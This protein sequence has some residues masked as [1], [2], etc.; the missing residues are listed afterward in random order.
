MVTRV[1]KQSHSINCYNVW[2]EEQFK[3][4]RENFDWIKV[5]ELT[6]GECHLLRYHHVSTEPSIKHNYSLI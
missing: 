4:V 2:L 3:C 1:E 5:K 6:S